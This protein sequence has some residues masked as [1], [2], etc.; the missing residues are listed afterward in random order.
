[1]VWFRV[2]FVVQ[3]YFYHDYRQVDAAKKDLISFKIHFPSL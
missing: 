2:G 3:Y 1:M